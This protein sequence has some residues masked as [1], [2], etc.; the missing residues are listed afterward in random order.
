MPK[1][2]NSRYLPWTFPLGPGCGRP[3]GSAQP[4]SRFSALHQFLLTPG[5]RLGAVHK[6]CHAFQAL[7]KHITGHG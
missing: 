2:I 6:V 5:S 4:W 1:C 7:T 3:I